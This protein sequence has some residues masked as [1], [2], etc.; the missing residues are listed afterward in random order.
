MHKGILSCDRDASLLE[1]A[2]TMAE[3]RVHRVVVERWRRRRPALGR[4]VGARPRRRGVRSRPGRADGRRL[5]RA[6]FVVTISAGETLERAAQLMT[7]HGTAHIIV[8]DEARLPVGVLDP[9]HREN[10]LEG[11]PPAKTASGVYARVVCGVDHSEAGIAA[12][13]GP[14]R[15]AGRRADIV[16]ADDT[17]RGV[18]RLGDAVRPDRAD[19]ARRAGAG[20]GARGGGAAARRVRQ[21]GRGRPPS[22][23]HVRDRRAGC[24]PRRRRQSRDPARNRPRSAPSRLTLHYA[25]RF[26][27]IARGE[28]DRERW[29]RRIVVGLDGSEESA[30]APP[31]R[32]SLPKAAK[33]VPLRAITATAGRARR[34][35]GGKEDRAD[36]RGARR[37]GAR[38]AQRRLRDG[39]PR[40]RRQP[41]PARRTRARQP[42]RA[43]RAR[44]AV[45][46]AGGPGRRQ[47]A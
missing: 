25:P 23:A 4:R 28:I 37:P 3:K 15:G 21:G 40:G 45:A 30:C 2:Q 36:L 27:L 17:G 32:R 5:R 35:R 16:A 26:V 18:R 19:A 47:A 24:D 20:R 6:A 38:R 11:E 7:E 46:G 12:R 14:R 34:P 10:A 8:I 13:A 44:G 31:P 9:R 29:P 33:D 41:R 1:V 22:R 43:P 42:Q 39:G